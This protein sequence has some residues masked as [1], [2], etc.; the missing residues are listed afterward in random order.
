MSKEPTMEA[1]TNFGKSEPAPVSDCHADEP[2]GATID[3]TVKVDGSPKASESVEIPEFIAPASQ[4]T[5][6][7]IV[8]FMEPNLSF[9]PEK[10]PFF[11][12]IENLVPLGCFGPFPTNNDTPTYSFTSQ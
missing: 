11:G 10:N 7:P 1:Q 2:S 5:T 9:G 4:S 3:P 12:S 6:A 8:S